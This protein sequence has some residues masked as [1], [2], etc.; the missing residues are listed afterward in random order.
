MS[1]I[2]EMLLDSYLRFSTAINNDRVVSEL[3]YNEALICNLLYR[4]APQTMT[5]T[6]LCEQTRIRKSQMARTLN[7]MEEKGLILR[8]RS[9]L[10]RR[11]VLVELNPEKAEVFFRQHQQTL[12]I[13]QAIA[14]KMTVEK[15]RQMTQLLNEAA[16]AAREVLREMGKEAL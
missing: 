2:T 13:V 9:R 6:D 14:E 8:T 15:A 7:E 5:A 11:Q 16:D 4:K 3:P 1:T 10:D 12:E